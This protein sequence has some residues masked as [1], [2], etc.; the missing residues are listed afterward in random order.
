MAKP[1]QMKKEPTK[2]VETGNLITGIA[3]GPDDKSVAVS[4][5]AIGVQV[6]DLREGKGVLALAVPGM[7]GTAVAWSPNGKSIVGGSATKTRVWNATTGMMTHEMSGAGASIAFTRDGNSLAIS[8]GTAVWA[9][10]NQFKPGTKPL[11]QGDARNLAWL[12][13]GKGLYG[14]QSLA[15]VGIEVE[16]GKPMRQI[17]VAGD[18]P[19]Q[20]TPGRPLITNTTSASPQLWD[21]ATGKQIAKLEGHAGAVTATAWSR[22]GKWLATGGTDKTVRVWAPAGN[23]ARM[24]VGHEGPVQCLAWADGKTLASG[25]VDKTVRVWS[26]TSDKAKV[27]K[28][29]KETVTALAWSKDG[30]QILSGD[31]KGTVSYWSADTDKPPVTMTARGGVQSVGISGTA[32]AL[33]V[34][35]VLG[36]LEIFNPTGGQPIHTYERPGSPPA[37]TSLAWAPDGLTLLAGRGNYS[38]QVWRLNSNAVVFDLPGMSPVTQVAWTGSGTGMVTSE[39]ARN[40]RVFDLS[41]GQLRGSIIPDGKQVAVVSTTGHYRVADEVACELVY[42]VQ[43]AKGQETLKPGEFATRF[44]FANKPTAVGVIDK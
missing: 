14:N 4:G 41:T 35:G 40:V 29:H 18:F 8:T 25:S 16:G 30:K 32:K 9:C 26:A 11:A 28:N 42:V 34:G 23:A 22:D 19:V 6:Y 43:T 24:L 5:N 2:T 36:E 38:S 20:L 21:V 15:V 39:S 33:A 12:P 13:D 27:F 10:D 31:E 37:V 17:D 7:N 44:R 1:E 3:W